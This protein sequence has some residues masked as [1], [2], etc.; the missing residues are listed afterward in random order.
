MFHSVLSICY[1]AITQVIAR[2]RKRLLIFFMMYSSILKETYVRFVSGRICS[3][4]ARRCLSLRC[5]WRFFGTTSLYQKVFTFA[6]FRQY[7]KSSMYSDNY[8]RLC[9]DAYI[10]IELFNLGNGSAY[11]SWLQDT[12]RKSS[13]P[14]NWHKIRVTCHKTRVKQTAPAAKPG[15][16]KSKGPQ[17]GNSK[18]LR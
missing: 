7:F 12:T 9:T 1:I 3:A 4:S 5:G 6:T 18:L 10:H 13:F 11:L 2:V 14:Q 17:N 16:E 8:K 15:Q